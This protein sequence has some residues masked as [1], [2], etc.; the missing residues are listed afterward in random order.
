MLAIEQDELGLPQRW[1]PVEK[2]RRQQC[3]VF[4]ALLAGFAP[5]GLQ[6]AELRSVSYV[7]SRL[8]A[9]GKR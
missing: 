6:A 4:V 8:G 2:P 7:Q 5:A 3:S 9:V 1:V